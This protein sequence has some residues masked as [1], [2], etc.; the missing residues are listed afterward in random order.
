MAPLNNDL[1]LF[2]THS[3]PDAKGKIN[4]ASSLDRPYYEDNN[5]EKTPREELADKIK[6]MS[7]KD[8]RKYF[9]KTNK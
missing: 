4:M 8:F 1:D 3:S 6:S 9:K 2:Y 5:K 7:R